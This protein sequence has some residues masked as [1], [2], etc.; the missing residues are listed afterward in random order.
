MKNLPVAVQVGILVVM[1]GMGIGMMLGYLAVPKDPETRAALYSLAAVLF[2]V[3]D[4]K[5]LRRMDE[6][7]NND[8]PVV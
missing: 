5:G 7:D 6:D 1:M 3:L 4:V 8:N 2:A